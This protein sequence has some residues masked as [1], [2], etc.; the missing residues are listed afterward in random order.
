MHALNV[1]VLNDTCRQEIELH[2]QKLIKHVKNYGNGSAIPSI[3][4]N[5]LWGSIKRITRSL[6]EP[7]CVYVRALF[8]YLSDMKPGVLM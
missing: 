7:V 5:H 8:L 3:G 1:K 6:C 4:S 2:V